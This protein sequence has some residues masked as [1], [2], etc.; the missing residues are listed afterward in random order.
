MFRVISFR[1]GVI[2]ND[3]AFECMALIYKTLQKKYGYK[4]TIVKSQQDDYHDFDLEIVSVSGKIWKPLPDMPFFPYAFARRKILEP[5][6]KNHDVILTVDPTRYYQGLIAIRYGH[7][8][9]LP[10]FFDASLTL[11]GQNMGIF[12]KFFRPIIKKALYQSTGIIVTVP[13][14]IERFNDLRLFNGS[15]APKFNIMGHPVDT[16]VFKPKPKRSEQDGILRILAVSRLVPEKGFLYILE[17]MDP[18]LKENKRCVFQILGSGP[19]K[20]LLE[21]EIRERHLDRQ[22]EFIKPVPHAELPEVLGSADVFVSHMVPD[23]RAEEA[24]GAVNL[25]AMACGLPSVLSRVGGIPYAVREDGVAVPVEPRNII[26]L[27]RSLKN[28][29]VSEQQRKEI[30][31]KARA[32]VHKYYGIDPIAE[33]YHKMLESS[34]VHK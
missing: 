20:G 33:K 30:G 15:I 22:V 17:A 18:L 5:L 2:G 32:Y 10:V 25:E 3:T 27:R 13:K 1:P 8:M 34:S 23:S 19:M 21:K 12:W 29:I 26:D 31:E 6:F 7:R 11:L 4:F 28:L 9:G 14:C 16:T 24:F